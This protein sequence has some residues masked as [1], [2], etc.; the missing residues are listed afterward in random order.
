MSAKKRFEATLII[1]LTTEMKERLDAI[2]GKEGVST[3]EV[4]RRLIEKQ[5]EGSR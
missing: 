4:A 2:A 1:K 3:A 5:L